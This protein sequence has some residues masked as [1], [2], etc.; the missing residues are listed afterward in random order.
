MKKIV[1]FLTIFE[2]FCGT[3]TLT[4]YVIVGRKLTL[5][6]HQLKLVLLVVID[7]M[8]IFHNHGC[9]IIRKFVSAVTAIDFFASNKN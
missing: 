2:I 4:C 6:K 3:S 8:V 7:L 9:V 5:M 1:H